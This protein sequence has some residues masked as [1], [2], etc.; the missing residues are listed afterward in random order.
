MIEKALY[1]GT[2]DPPTRGH[3]WMIRE[4]LNYTDELIVAVGDNSTK[5]PNF[6]VAERLKMLE[7]L[8]K[9]EL[10]NNAKRVTVTAFA[11]Q[12]LANFMQEI[13]AEVLF[14]GLR[15]GA[16]FAAERTMQRMNQQIVPSTKTLYLIPPSEIAEISSSTVRSLIG[17][18]GW[19]AVTAHYLPASVHAKITQMKA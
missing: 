6:T 13:G 17:Y 3:L 8:L 16:D 15:S 18:T 11:G 7:G 14:R 10:K 9:N 5:I 4:A 12:Y 1:A 19:E 2:F